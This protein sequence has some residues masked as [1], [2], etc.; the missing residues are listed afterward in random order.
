MLAWLASRQLR[1]AGSSQAV[2]SY[3]HRSNCTGECT[4]ASAM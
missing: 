2:L 1:T 4:D 3:E